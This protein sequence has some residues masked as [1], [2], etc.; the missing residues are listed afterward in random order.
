M[1]QSK[2]LALGLLQCDATFLVNSQPR[3]EGIASVILILVFQY[4]MAAAPLVGAAITLW[5]VVFFS[6]TAIRW[7][8]DVVLAPLVSSGW[9]LN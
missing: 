9:V 1:S 6:L 7:A 8:P 5:L 3:V 2:K 4:C